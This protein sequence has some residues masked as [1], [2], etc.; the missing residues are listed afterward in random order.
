[1]TFDFSNTLIEATITLKDPQL[2]DEELQN[3]VQVIRGE[4]LETKVVNEADLIPIKDAPPGSKP[5]GGFV[6]GAFKAIADLTQ[7][8][9]L[10]ESL[11]NRL[12]GQTIEIEV[13]KRFL[14]GKKLKITLQS[15]DDLPKAMSEIDKFM[16][17]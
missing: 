1:M 13:E 5:L 3:L 2:N 8:K 11:G 16:K 7:L 15:V 17:G 14:G 4:L 6:T 9:P 10:A 12:F